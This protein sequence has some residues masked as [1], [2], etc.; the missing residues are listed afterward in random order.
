MLAGV[1]ALAHFVPSLDRDKSQ[2]IVFAAVVLCAVVYVRWGPL[3][4]ELHAPPPG[5]EIAVDKSLEATLAEDP[6]YQR[7]VQE[8]DERNRWIERV[9]SPNRRN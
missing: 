3:L 4:S 1:V 7:A 9:N 2:I 8:E 6:E 5:A